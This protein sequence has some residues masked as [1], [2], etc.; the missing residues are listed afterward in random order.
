[1]EQAS[2]CHFG[3]A[4]WVA[5]LATLVGILHSSTMCC[6]QKTKTTGHDSNEARKPQTYFEPQKTHD[7]TILQAKAV[8]F[9]SFLCLKEPRQPHLLI[10][11]PMCL[12]FFQLQALNTTPHSMAELLRQRRYHFEIAGSSARPQVE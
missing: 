12:A 9:G 8:D 11:S 7:R 2:A 3:M 4:P 1:M 10:L 5:T 6:M